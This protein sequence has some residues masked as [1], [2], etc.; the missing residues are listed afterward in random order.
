MQVIM[1][2][3]DPQRPDQVQPPHDRVIQA[4]VTQL[5]RVFPGEEL[6]YIRV[7]FSQVTL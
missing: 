2:K 6:S 4:D 7:G 3:A 1:V 5:I